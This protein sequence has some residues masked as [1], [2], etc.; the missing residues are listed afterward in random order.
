[1]SIV[2]IVILISVL[3]SFIGVGIFFLIRYLKSKKTE[4]KYDYT[5]K[6]GTR[7]MLSPQTKN[8]SVSIFEG[9]S[10]SVVNFWTEETGWDKTKCYEKLSY[11][12]MKIFDA[13]FLERN[14]SK[15]SGLV[16]PN[17]FLIE[18]ST[19]PKGESQA[20][21]TRLA[22][23]FRH[24]VSHIIAGYVGGLEA[25]PNGGEFHHKLFAEVGLKA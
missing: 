5:T 16:W 24:E 6:Y 1:M 11:T 4:E 13:E 2:E 23:L 18:V 9:W 25:G 22:S 15:V 21:I 10:N 14:G 20:S 12:E 19:F 17:T 7:I 3:S 8:M